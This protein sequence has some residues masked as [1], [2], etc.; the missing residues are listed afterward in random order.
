MAIGINVTSDVRVELG[1]I[2]ELF[3]NELDNH[4]IKYTIPF[5]K[6][7]K[8]GVKDTFISIVDKDTEINVEND[9]I[10]YIKSGNT[11][12]THL[13]TVEYI[14]SGVLE[15]IK[16]IKDNINKRFNTIDNNIKIEKIDTSTINMTLIITD[17][18]N[19]KARVQI[20][21][22]SF[23]EVYINTIRAL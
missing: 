11:E 13:D 15:H 12:F 16:I 9:I 5:D 22:D 4:N 7:N 8:N 18:N 10:V 14:D 20:L 2:K 21:R 17:S 3:L 6:I 1:E 19:N 23:G